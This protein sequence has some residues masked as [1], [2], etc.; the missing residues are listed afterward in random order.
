MESKKQNTVKQTNK[1]RQQQKI[2][3]RKISL[4]PVPY[5]ASSTNGYLVVLL[6]QYIGIF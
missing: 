4:Y 6:S 2:K 5:Y 1:R 3:N